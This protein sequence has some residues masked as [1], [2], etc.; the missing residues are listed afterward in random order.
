MKEQSRG[1]NFSL[2]VSVTTDPQ[3]K[4]E[5]E[6]RLRITY[7]IFKVLTLC[8]GSGT[9]YTQINKLHPI[10]AKVLS[11]STIKFTLVLQ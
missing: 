3:L 6:N 1:R 7:S 10:L 9:S 11:S 4:Q 5:P 8:D 2:L